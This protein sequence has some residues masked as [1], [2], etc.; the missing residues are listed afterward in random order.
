MDITLGRVRT[1]DK[2]S[3][4]DSLLAQVGEHGRGAGGAIG[5]NRAA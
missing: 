2:G 3:K 5:C 1:P 4:E